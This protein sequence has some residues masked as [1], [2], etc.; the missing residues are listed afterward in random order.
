MWCGRISRIVLHNKQLFLAMLNNDQ[1]TWERMKE[2][3]RDF[4]RVTH[5]DALEG[6][7]D[8]LEGAMQW[9]TIFIKYGPEKM[10]LLTENPCLY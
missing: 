2:A 3:H 6:S 7:V 4:F 8:L 9:Y 1:A 5:R 10:K